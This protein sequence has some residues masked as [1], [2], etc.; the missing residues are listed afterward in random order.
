MDTSIRLAVLV[1]VFGA[2]SKFIIQNVL[3][4]PHVQKVLNNETNSFSE[5]YWK[6][7]VPGEICTTLRELM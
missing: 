1:V 7:M 5:N 2:N 3:A 4:L 6:M